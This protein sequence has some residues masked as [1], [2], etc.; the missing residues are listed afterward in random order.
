MVN[1][2]PGTDAAAQGGVADSLLVGHHPWR[3]KWSGVSR[4]VTYIVLV[5]LGIVLAGVGFTAK[6]ETAAAVAA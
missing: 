5:V 2:L 6:P 4:W 3:S 1:P